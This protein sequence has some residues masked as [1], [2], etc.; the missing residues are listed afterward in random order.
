MLILVRSCGLGGIDVRPVVY[1]V[2]G[3]KRDWSLGMQFCT[4]ASQTKKGW[5]IS[6]VKQKS[7]DQTARNLP[8]EFFLPF[9]SSFAR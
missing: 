4:A 5:P 9:V 7:E 2:F 1:G 3:L 6:I 8:S